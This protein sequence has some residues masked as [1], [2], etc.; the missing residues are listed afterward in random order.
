MRRA[1][2]A[3]LELKKTTPNVVSLALLQEAL[4]AAQHEASQLK[5]VLISHIK[6]QGRI[7]VNRKTMET[8]ADTDGMSATEHSDCVVFEYRSSE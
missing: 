8:L 6:D 7:A 2:V 5:L 1:I 4:L 3:K